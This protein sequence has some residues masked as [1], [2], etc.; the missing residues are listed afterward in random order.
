MK[1]TIMGI[2]VALILVMTISAIAKWGAII[3]FLIL[4]TGGGYVGYK[5]FSKKNATE[6]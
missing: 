6:N 2:I 1:K 3:F 4:L 5:I